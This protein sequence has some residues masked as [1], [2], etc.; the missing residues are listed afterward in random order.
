MHFQIQISPDEGF[1]KGLDASCKHFVAML[2]ESKAEA[3]PGAGASYTFV[4]NVA[5]LYPHEA[6][7]ISC[8]S[9]SSK[10][11]PRNMAAGSQSQVRKPQQVVH[12]IP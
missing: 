11:A 7:V 10:Q 2:S 6:C 1:W 8:V 9:G 5:P 12:P 4:F 3:H